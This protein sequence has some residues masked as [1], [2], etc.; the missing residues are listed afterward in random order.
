MIG[1]FT[2]KRKLADRCCLMEIGLLTGVQK[3]MITQQVIVSNEIFPRPLCH[4][5]V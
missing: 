4:K 3:K 5:Y 1:H 2:D